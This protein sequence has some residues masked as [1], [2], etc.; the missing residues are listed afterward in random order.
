MKFKN[1]S[2]RVVLLAAVVWGAINS[3]SSAFAAETEI[4]NRSSSN[5]IFSYLKVSEDDIKYYKRI[6]HFIEIEDFKSADKEIKKLDNNILMGHVQAEKFL[7]K[8]YKSSFGELKKWLENYSDLPQAA[9]IYRLAKRKGNPSE[10]VCPEEINK[11]PYNFYSWVNTDLSSLSVANKKFVIEKI[12]LFRKS[13]NKGQTKAARFVVENKQFNK[14]VPNKDIDSMIATLAMKYLLDNEDKMAYEWGSKASKRSNDASASWV[15]GLA[16]WRMRQYKNADYYFTRLA[17]SGNSDE[18]LVSAGAYWAYRSNLA[19]KKNSEANKWLK[20]T[21]RYKRTFYG[22]LAN[23][24]LGQQLDYNWTALSYLNDFSQDGY[25]DEILASGSIRRSLLLLHA[26]QPDLAE[27]ELRHSYKDMNDKQKEV[28]LFIANQYK[29]HP[30]AVMLSN[31]LKDE[32]RNIAY[33]SIAY[34]VPNWKPK[35]GWKVDKALVLALTRQESAFSPKAKSSAGAC[36]LM[37]LLPSTAAHITKDLSLKK[38]ISPLLEAEYNMSLGQKYVNYLL[39]KPFID[40]NL[41]YL[42]TAYNGGPGNLLKWQKNARYNEDPLLF[43]E[44]IP[45]RET[46]IYIERVMANLWIYQS[47]F[48]QEMSG[49]KSL[50]KSQWPMLKE[51]D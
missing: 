51:K 40:G 22:I 36:G 2:I 23:Y 4:I 28:T 35:G 29:M 25:I 12:E 8:S 6:F 50:S 30:L 10:L 47:R 3:S 42:M 16:A 15:A 33:D 14:L 32:G 38:N 46:R 34:P 21:S 18:W 39:E 5:K 31:R 13:I 49:I 43:I 1:L 20:I 11:V 41:F 7:S 24:N 9:S 17:Q 26:K 27:K 48:G 37:Q 45:A 19:L 44:V